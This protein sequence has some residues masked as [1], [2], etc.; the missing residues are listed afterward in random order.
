MKYFKLIIENQKG[1]VALTTV[2]TILAAGV[3][4]AVA[5]GILTF[6]EIKKINNVE[7]SVQ[8]YYAAEAGVEDALL[9]T[10]NS[11]NY[12]ASYTL[13][14]GSATATVTIVGPLENLSIVSSGNSENRIR[15]IAV[16]LNATPSNI[17][18]NFN[19]G[20]QVGA[21]GL[22][23]AA[24][25]RVLGNVYSNGTI[26]GASSHPEIVGDAFSVGIGG[27]INRIDIVKSDPAASDGNGHS[28]TINNSNVEDTP[29]CQEGSGNNK[30][31]DT[32]ESDPTS[33]PLPLTDD[34]INVLKNQAASGGE[35]PTTT[36]S[37]SGN[38]LGPKKI[39]GDLTISSNSEL[40]V[41]G[42]IWVTGD[43]TFNSNSLIKLDSSFGT[44]SGAF[45]ADG[46]II[47]DS[48]VTVCGSNGGIAG[49][50]NANVNESYIMF[51][52]TSTST[53]SSDPA[54]SMSANTDAAILYSS[55]GLTKV[56]ANTD[57]FE[58]TAY[59]LEIESNASV[60]YQSGLADTDFSSG[61]GGVFNIKSWQEIQ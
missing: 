51:L 27:L 42:T 10:K 57:V 37:G 41:T 58:I 1:Q 29:F 47:L 3:V 15:K 49:S 26:E 9:R 7:K 35:Q 59:Q 25:S 18:S 53:S 55:A 22:Q 61:P 31:C 12:A 50:C 32:S 38:T 23:M 46:E 48:N 24:F 8:S 2:I 45:V 34:D 39:N 11:M 6:N 56:N 4:L 19:Y 60:S 21:G 28:H 13:A 30:T 40:T 14:V 20:V 17:N 36:I 43:I 52:S 5:L 54:I 44:D 16:N 33:I